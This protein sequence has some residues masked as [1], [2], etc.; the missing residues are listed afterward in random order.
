FVGAQHRAFDSHVNCEG[1]TMTT[2]HNHYKY[3]HLSVVIFGL[4]SLITPVANAQ[5][6]TAEPASQPKVSAS[7]KSTHGVVATDHPLASKLGAD[8]LAKGGNAADA[9]VTAMLAL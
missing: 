1:H 9:G 8:I 4:L 3:A 7:V 5:S 6:P 2:W